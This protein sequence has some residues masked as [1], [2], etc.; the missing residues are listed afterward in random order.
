MAISKHSLI[1]SVN[2]GT[3][4]GEKVAVLWSDADK[5]IAIQ[6][7]TDGDYE[8]RQEGKNKSSRSVYC[9][10]LI[11][12]KKI[13]KGRYTTQFDEKNHMLIARLP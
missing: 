8:F 11:E 5:A 12:T 10:G 2:V 3:T 1:L 13:M 7:A 6:K 4:L 9:K